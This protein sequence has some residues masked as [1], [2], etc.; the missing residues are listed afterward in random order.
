M[1][2]EVRLKPLAKARIATA[3]SVCLVLA[4]SSGCNAFGNR[5]LV[6]QLENENARLLS[7]FRAERER[8]EQ[9]ERKTAS[10]ENRLAESEKLLASQAVP[11]QGRLS[12]LPSSQASTFAPDALS[13]GFSTP[14]GTSRGSNSSGADAQGE[15]FGSTDA[16]FKWQRRTK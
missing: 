9:A 4:I 16:G 15:N 10:L 3:C 1:L 7:E 5:T 2:D 12:S 8:R 11:L 14:S 13:Q 6:Q